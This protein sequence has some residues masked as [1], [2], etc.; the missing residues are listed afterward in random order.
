MS[1]N[2][3][4][5]HPGP[6]IN[7]TLWDGLHVDVRNCSA[8]LAKCNRPGSTDANYDG[9]T[10]STAY[11]FCENNIAGP[12]EDHSGRS[13]YDTRRKPGDLPEEKWEAAFLNDA[14]NQEAM[15]VDKAAGE[16]HN[17]TWVECADSSVGPQFAK[18]GDEARD[19]TWA[20][21]E[22]L[23]RGVRTLVYYGDR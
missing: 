15:G 18:S 7:K 23:E 4:R 8:L 21:K 22:V 6:F 1:C 5:T 17:G 2:G 3:T 14:K 19:S 13:T 9:Q 11:D 20:V 16:K 12:F 10:C